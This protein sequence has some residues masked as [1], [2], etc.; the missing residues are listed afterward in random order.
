MPKK[1]KK[2]VP[3]TRPVV[4]RPL[5]E[6]R[7]AVYLDRRALAAFVRLESQAEYL[8]PYASK[9]AVP[10]Y[11]FE[12]VEKELEDLRCL[13]SHLV[14]VLRREGINPFSHAKKAVW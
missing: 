9:E 4:F 6:E 5:P 1:K 8:D 13:V 7:A 11:R 2:E 12:A 3:A 14:L 10:R